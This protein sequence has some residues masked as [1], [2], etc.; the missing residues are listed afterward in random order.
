ML[1]K[2]VLKQSY[3]QT[4]NV[5]KNKKKQH[6]KTTFFCILII[7]ADLQFSFPDSKNALLIRIEENRALVYHPGRHRWERLEDEIYPVEK[8]TVQAVPLRGGRSDQ[9]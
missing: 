4:K 3:F 1:Q 6:F 5:Y 8:S 7:F 9:L 2:I